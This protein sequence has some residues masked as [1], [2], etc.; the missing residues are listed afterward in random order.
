VIA[1]LREGNGWWANKFGIQVGGKYID[2]FGVSN[3]DLQGEIN[4]VR[5]YTYTHNSSYGNYSNYQQPLAH[6]LGANFKE[7]IGILRYQPLPRLNLT[8]KL[9]LIQT[10]RDTVNV[11]W[12]GDIFKS[13]SNRPRTFGNTIGQGFSNEIWYAS[14]SASW[15]LRHNIFVDAGIVLRKSESVLAFYNNNTAISSLA[16]RWNIPQRFYEF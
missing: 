8:G 15:Q 13:N 9:M 11:N 4:V 2:A 5:P 1:N 3:L 12:G 7:A 10:G 6:P 14:F 16:L